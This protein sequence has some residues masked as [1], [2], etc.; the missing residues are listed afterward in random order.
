MAVVASETYT[1]TSAPIQYAAVR[2]FH[3]GIEIEQYLAQSRR[4]LKELGQ[5]LAGQLREFGIP[6]SNP[7]GAFY[8]FPDFGQYREKLFARDI[9]TSDQLCE[10]L[11]NENGVAALPGRVFGRQKEEL[12]VRLAYVD[13]DGARALTAAQQ[14]PLDKP[15]NH[16]FL[17]YYCSGPIKAVGRL[18]DWLLNS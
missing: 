1:A 18:G 9:R 11:L 15:L 3:G 6:I 13:F 4:I 10:S 14:I 8:L 5:N 12:T 2:A 7:Q 16:D 17:S